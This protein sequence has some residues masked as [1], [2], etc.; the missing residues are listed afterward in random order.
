M[1]ERSPRRDSRS[2]SRTPPRRRSNSR[3]RSPPRRRSRSPPR[4]RPARPTIAEKENPEPSAV[5]GVFG[6]SLRTTERDLDELFAKYGKVEKVC[7]VYDNYV[8]TFDL[9]LLR[10]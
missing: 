6:L 9:V 1:E 8:S 10:A 3:S 5:L 4:Y 7:V 2:R